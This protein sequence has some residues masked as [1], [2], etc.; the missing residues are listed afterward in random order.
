LEM[1]RYSTL[2][3]LS[4][5]LSESVSD[6]ES[7]KEFLGN[8]VRESETLLQQQ[9]RISTDLQE[10]LMRTRMIKFNGLSSRLA[11]I[12]RQTSRELGKNVEFEIIGDELEVD[13]SILDRIVSPLEHL[14]RN[15]VAHG[16]E[17]NEARVVLNKTEPGKVSVRVSKEAQDLII[18]VSDNGSGINVDAIRKSAIAKGMLTSDNEL[19]DHDIVQFILEPGFSTAKE[20]TQISGRGVGLDVVD[21]EIKQ[22]GGTLDIESRINKGCQFIARLP[23][24]LSINQALLVH[25]QEDIF[26]VP[27]NTIEGIVRLSGY[28]LEMIYEK[29]TGYYEFGDDKYDVKYLG[30]LLKGRKPDYLEQAAPYPVLL[31]KTGDLRVAVHVDSLVGRR[32]IVVKP[33]GSQISTVKGVSGATILGDGHVVLILD[34][35][36]LLRAKST[37][38]IESHAVEI[39]REAEKVQSKVLTVMVVDDSITIRK[40]TERILLRN[41]MEVILAKDGLDATAKLQERLP[42]I[43]LLDIEMPRMDGYE[44]ATMVRNNEHMKDLPIIMITSRTGTKHKD[45]AMEIGVNRYLGKP[46]QEDELLENIHAVLDEVKVS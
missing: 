15:A 6:L 41:D 26:A 40:V 4:R 25:L 39:Q 45:K 36:S 22:L 31:V 21:S 3:Q 19:N 2:Q 11:R 34:M 23:M 27:L 17:T 44:V 20:V 38:H 14:L 43:M 33:V 5:S 18:N 32:E 12:V 7:I 46:Y 42:D 30:Y 29:G 37:F 10:S 8:T 13:R 28:E 1:D 35:A 16:I 24:T 9:S